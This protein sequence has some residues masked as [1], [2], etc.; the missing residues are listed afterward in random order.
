MDMIKGQGRV[1]GTMQMWRKRLASPATIVG[2]AAF[3][4][5]FDISSVAVALPDIAR[6][7]GGEPIAYNNVIIAYIVGATA[8]LP[9]C[10]WAV[11]RFGPRR[12]FLMAVALFGISATVCG[13]ATTIPMLLAARVIQGAAGAMLLPVGRVIVLGSVEEKGFVD[14]MAALTMPLMLGPVVGPP[15]AGALITLGSWRLLFLAMLPL[16]VAGFALVYRRIEAIPALHRH[17][18]DVRGSLLL[19]GALA[20]VAIGIG[21]LD[22]AFEERIRALALTGSGLLLFALYMLHERRHPRAVLS[23]AP[24]KRPLMRATNIGGIFPRMLTSSTPFLLAI[25]F[26]Q[27]FG[28]SAAEAGGLIFAMAIGSLAGRAIVPTILRR[29]G[30]RT[31]LLVNGTGMAAVLAACSLFEPGISVTV[32]I[33]VLFLLGLLRSNQLIALSA[34]GYAGMPKAEFSAAS[35]ISSLSQQLAQGVGIAIAVLSVQLIS[36]VAP[37]DESAVAGAFVVLAFVSMLSLLWVV[38]L[39]RDSGDEMSGRAGSPA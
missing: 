31:M 39:A 6:E 34:L 7:F 19:V 28:M 1:S 9:L 27:R 32:I 15:F 37:A 13:L 33:A 18:L 22:G 12:I 4:Q 21:S 29:V 11:D 24:M 5:A 23:L 25:L 2:C 38:A 36:M 16:S 3:V 17:P 30:F 20:A 10:G 26:Q 14:A 35:T 8:I